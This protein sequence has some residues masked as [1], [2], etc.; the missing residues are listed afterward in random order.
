MT[1]E[2]P[3]WKQAAKDPD[4]PLHEATWTLF[5]EKMNVKRAAERLEPHKEAVIPYLLEIVR[6]EKLQ[7]ETAPGEG[8]AP[9]NAVDLLG[10]W[11]VTEGVPALLAII[12]DDDHHEDIT[13]MWDRALYAMERMGEA[14]IEPL[15]DAVERRPDMKITFVG[16]LSSLGVKDERITNLLTSTLDSLHPSRDEFDYPHMAESLLTY[17]KEVGIA[18]FEEGL[19][20]G[21]Y[22]RADRK[23]IQDYIDDAREGHFDKLQDLKSDGDTS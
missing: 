10:E 12:E 1:D 13:I 3:T 22:S 18:Y 15:L 14:P 16:L 11:R 9:I 2:A 6:N 5:R 17:D 20:K 19:R 4:H 8:Y 7:L 21:R 23:F